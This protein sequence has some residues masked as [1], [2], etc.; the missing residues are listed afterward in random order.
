MN[1]R[2]ET[3]TSY[4]LILFE[5]AN[6]HIGNISTLN[7]FV[8]ITLEVS[9]KTFKSDIRLSLG[10]F[11]LRALLQVLSFDSCLSRFRL[12]FSYLSIFPRV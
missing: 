1:H 10:S 12:T 5:N 3:K 11:D 2:S 4:L 6:I 7:C 9:N 8:Y